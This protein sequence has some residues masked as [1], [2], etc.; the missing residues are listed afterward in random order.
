VRAE[1]LE[2]HAQESALANQTR[3]AI[4]SG[5]E[6]VASWR[7]V[8]NAEAQSRVLRLLAQEYR[9]VG[10]RAGA[11]QSAADAIAVI[12]KL[13]ASAHLA[14]AYGA[15][16]LLALHRG[17]NREA[18]EFSERALELARNAG[19]R[20][21]ECH[22]LCHFGGALLGIG[23]RAGYAPLERSLALALENRLED[24]AARAYRTLQFY[25]ALVRDYARAEQAF[26]EGVEYCEERGIFSHSTYI[27]TYYTVCKLDRGEWTEAAHMATEL[28]R[29]AEVTGVTQRVTVMT[30][31]AVVR[32][33]RGDPGADEL[34]DEALSLCVPTGEVIRIARVAAARAERAWYCGRLADVARETA[35][36]LEHT[37]VHNT[38]W[39]NGEL[40]FWKSRTEA[41][42]IVGEVAEPYRLMLAGDWQ[43]AATAWEQIGA[44]YEQALA[45]AD[46]T[47]EAL[48]QA[49]TIL[50]KLGG[51]SLATIVRRN[52]RDRGVRGIPRGPKQVTR[53]NPLG[54][55]AREFEVLQLL[56]KGYTSAQ[57]ARCLH[58]SPK[59]VDHHVSALLG[60]LGVHSRTEAVAIAFARGMD[61]AAISDKA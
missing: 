40:L 20:A 13:P 4:T 25:A 6:A 10:D 58:R 14:M 21:A 31:L 36:G 16:A 45:L 44:P 61:T 42:G 12:E 3:E 7:E 52:L 60:K 1:I 29:G 51:A 56:A 5:T 47:E 38:P 23:D 17:W 55:T 43:G 57:L 11:D 41:T 9:T 18:L 34:L 22:A 30:T 26:H 35:I 28:M 8:G 32:L 54:L 37:R 59:T 53:R 46:G 50:D 39:L 2:C 48:R 15:R 27:R 33:R 19:D 24:E 49:L